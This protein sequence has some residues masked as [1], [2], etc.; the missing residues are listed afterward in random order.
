MAL[1]VKNGSNRWAATLS[2]M[3]GPLS[4]MRTTA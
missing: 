4:A 1:V 3:P 2:E